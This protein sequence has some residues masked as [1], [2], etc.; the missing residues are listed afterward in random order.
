M[1]LMMTLDNLSLSSEQKYEQEQERVQKS[2]I[3]YKHIT[4]PAPLEKQTQ[5]STF[6][7]TSYNT[8]SKLSP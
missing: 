1:F 8:W 5:V 6:F 4:P 7:C 3:S 2:K